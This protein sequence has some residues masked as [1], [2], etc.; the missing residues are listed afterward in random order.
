MKLYMTPG[1]C[2]MGIHILLEELELLFEAHIVNLLTGD[3]RRPE[4]LAINPRGSVPTLVKDDG[5]ALTDFESIAVWLA[6]TYPKRGLLPREPAQRAKAIETLRYAVNVLHGEGFTRIFVS[7]RYALHSEEMSQVQSEGR[8]LVQHGFTRLDA[9][10]AGRR[11]IVDEF[12]IADAALCYLELWAERIQ[13]SMPANLQ[14]H[15]QRMVARPA[16]RQVLGEE[17]YASTLRKYA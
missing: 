10:L 6:D 7:E 3:N 9:L 17:G 8:S 1:S 13:L 4:F 16:V 5:T 11:W 2:S 15:F 14:A 12:S